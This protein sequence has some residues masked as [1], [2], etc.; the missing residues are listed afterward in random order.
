MRWKTTS[1]TPPEASAQD[2][3]HDSHRNNF[4]K[5]LWAHA[6]HQVSPSVSHSVGDTASS[7]C[8]Q[9]AD[10]PCCTGL[11]SGRGCSSTWT[12]HIASDR[13]W[14]QGHVLGLS[15]G[16]RKT[17]VLLPFLPTEQFVHSKCAAGRESI[18]ERHQ[19]KHMTVVLI[20]TSL[21]SDL[22]LMRPTAL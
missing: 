3:K 1:F 5:L 17:Q 2:W 10:S 22:S 14:S 20:S 16:I 15:E 6:Q 13:L 12:T 21:L 9:R 19:G 4:W 8:P 18:L 11:S 7:G